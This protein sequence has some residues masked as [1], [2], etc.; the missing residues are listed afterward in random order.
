M[1]LEAR[2]API[3]CLLAPHDHRGNGQIGCP[4]GQVPHFRALCG[5]PDASIHAAADNGVDAKPRASLSGNRFAL[6]PGFLANAGA[7]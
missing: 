6:R 7:Q 3:L 4:K 2:L 1:A 5:W